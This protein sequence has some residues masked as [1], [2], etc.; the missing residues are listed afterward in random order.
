MVNQ[1]FV[2][3]TKRAC[4]GFFLRHH[5]N[6]LMKK[7]ILVRYLQGIVMAVHLQGV[8]EK[9]GDKHHTSGL[10]EFV[11]AIFFYKS[12]RQPLTSLLL[13]K[14]IQPYLQNL[15]FTRLWVSALAEYRNRN[16]LNCVFGALLLPFM[17]F[18]W[19]KM[20]FA[21]LVHIIEKC[22]DDY[23]CTDAAGIKQDSEKEENEWGNWQ[24][25]LGGKSWPVKDNTYLDSVQRCVSNS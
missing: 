11:P 4:R 18:R 3:D 1:P 9:S 5:V 6:N 14:Q 20:V 23:S 2:T 12:L 13:Q 10:L 19:E 16:C 15:P 7:K 17:L 25:H 22:K 8:H 24:K 21:A